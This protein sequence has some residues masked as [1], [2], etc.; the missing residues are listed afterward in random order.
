MVRAEG[1][2]LWTVNDE[3]TMEPGKFWLTYT[4]ASAEFEVRDESMNRR[5]N[6]PIV[7][8]PVE[9]QFSLQH[10]VASEEQK[11]LG[12]TFRRVLTR[13]LFDLAS[14]SRGI[15]NAAHA[16]FPWDFEGGQFI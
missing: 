16:R 4:T 5:V 15:S 6:L 3:R 12:L 13:L 1:V 10:S 8:G 9:K 11:N 2:K 14:T 7:L